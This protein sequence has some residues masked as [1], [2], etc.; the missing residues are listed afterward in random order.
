MLIAIFLV[1]LL[2]ISAVSANELNVA[3]EVAIDDNNLIV[4]VLSEDISSDSHDDILNAKDAGT[5]TALQNKINNANNGSTIILENDYSYDEGFDERGIKI[6]KPLTIDG[7]DHTINALSKSRIFVVESD[8]VI[9]KNIKFING[10]APA[11]GGA[12][13]SYASDS[14]L[15][16]SIFINNVA[17]GN[18][19][20]IYVKGNN[21]NI[22]NSVSTSNTGWSGGAICSAGMNCRISDSTFTNNKAIKSIAYT[23]IG[24]DIYPYYPGG[25]GGAINS[26]GNACEISNS[27]FKGNTADRYGGAI[28]VEGTNTKISYCSYS[29]DDSEGNDLY[30][31]ASDTVVIDPVEIIVKDVSKYY[32]GFEKLTVELIKDNKA[33]GNVNVNIAIDGKTSTITTNSNGQAS[34]DLN[35]P[36]GTH[37]VVTEYGGVKVNSKVTVKSTIT[38]NDATGTYSNSKVTATFLNTDGKA[39]ANTK[40]TF[41]IN[42]KEYPATTNSNG[43]AT[44][45]IPL[46]VDTHTVTAV[47]P[48]NNEQ[49]Q[50]K[51][52]ISK[53]TSSV[54]L[55]AVQNGK[56]VTLTATVT[57]NAATGK[58]TFDV[59]GKT[60]EATISNGKASITISDLSPASY[61]AKATYGGDSN[62]KTS[63]ASTTI[64]VDKVYSITNVGDTEGTYLNTKVSATFLDANGKALANTKVTFKAGGKSFSTTTDS[65]GVA[66][67]DVDLEVGNYNVT[68]LNPATKEE[69]QFKLSI[70]LAGAKIISQN[71]NT[72]YA[73]GTFTFKLVDAATNKPL[74]GKKLSYSIYNAGGSVTTDKNGIATIDNSNLQMIKS[75][76]Y[77]LTFKKNLD[78][79]KHP[80]TIKGDDSSITVAEFKDYIT[81]GQATINIKIDSYNE[82]F[83]SGKKLGI[84]VTNAKT[85]VPMKGVVLHLYMPNTANKDYYVQTGDDGIAEIDVS[86]L[87]PSVYSLSVVNN[88]TKNIVEKKVSG[89]IT[90]LDP[91]SKTTPILSAKSVQYVYGNTKQYVVT[92]TQSDGT[93]IANEE[94][95]VI[96]LGLYTDSSF[97]SGG[98]FTTDDNGQAK[99]KLSG[100]TPDTYDVYINAKGCKELH[101]TI[102]I[103]KA[104]P[105]LTVASKTFK[106]ST[107]TKKYTITLKNSKNKA[108]K[109]VKVTL[110]VNGKTYTAKTNSYGKATFKITKL[111]KKGKFT[112]TVKYAG[113]K[114]YKAKSVSAKITV[115]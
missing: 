99:L 107:K 15:I 70:S 30:S 1:S 33:L 111:T 92:L 87:N 60:R 74:T 57:P 51:L 3:D 96:G 47:N 89:T 45:D 93:P 10:N 54:S 7:N 11:A 114:Y 49:K 104:T 68:A 37:N 29:K 88:D 21:Y 77:V 41:K 39:L 63:T 79:G 16:N 110:K 69:K 28:Y 12:I 81:V 9:L 19:G 4:D 65:N 82:Y 100:F 84:T 73:S 31:D 105:K 75:E 18:G 64:N 13:Y 94:I 113:N 71:L 86:G 17:D 55:S 80:I 61:P 40:V 32:G 62:Y 72:E 56:S 85:G 46:G 23:Q 8:N 66:T 97:S 90:I 101:T 36:V 27:I 24:S 52:T 43:V 25:Y 38:A 6:S 103:K 34:V 109:K 112:A 22:V 59:N 53:A 67:A 58:V 115:K 78:V 102:V 50:F 108:L 106:A 91:A 5:F 76:N 48:A 44:A 14:S 83:Q 35:L 26:E 2:A 95:E 98:A 20:A 42:G